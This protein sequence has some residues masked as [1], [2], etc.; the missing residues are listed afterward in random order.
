MRSLTLPL[1]AAVCIAAN[2]LIPQQITSYRPCCYDANGRLRAGASCCC[3]GRDGMEPAI[4]VACTC[5]NPIF[6]TLRPSPA[7]SLLGQHIQ[8]SPL[9][10]AALASVNSAV[11]MNPVYEVWYV[12]VYANGPPPKPNLLKLYSR[13]NI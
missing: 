10:D 8:K 2:L 9:P 13:L 12:R 4:G 11:T 3:E 5:C 7:S 1:L 6:H